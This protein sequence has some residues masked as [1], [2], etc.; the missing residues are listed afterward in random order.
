MFG[1]GPQPQ[2]VKERELSKDLD[3]YKLMRDQGHTPPSVDGAA[4]LADLAQSDIEI[5]QGKLI[6][7]A[8]MLREVES[9]HAQAPPPALTPIDAA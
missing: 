1:V 6:R 9:L 7:N 2:T 3:A 4:R 8:R 5:T